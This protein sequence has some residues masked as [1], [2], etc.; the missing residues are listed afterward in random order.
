[1]KNRSGW[2]S[3]KNSSRSRAVA[4]GVAQRAVD[5]FGV[6]DAHRDHAEALLGALLG[7]LEDELD[8]LKDLGVAAVLAVGLAGR[9]TG[10]A[11]AAGTPAR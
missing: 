7:V 6:L 8:D 5:A 9:A 11:R 10:H 2:F 3:S 1:M 4:Q